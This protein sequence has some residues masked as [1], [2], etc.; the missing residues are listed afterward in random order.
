MSQAAIKPASMIRG[1]EHFKK[2][3]DNSQNA[4]VVKIS[5]GEY[6]ITDRHESFYDTSAS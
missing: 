6:Y 5:P 2:F 1:F 4:N 3:Y